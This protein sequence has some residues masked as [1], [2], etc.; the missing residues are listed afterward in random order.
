MLIG[1]PVLLHNWL[2]SF[3]VSMLPWIAAIVGFT[4]GLQANGIFH[5]WGHFIGAR[6]LGGNVPTNPWNKL[7]PM[8]HFDMAS[9]SHRQF[10]GM[11]I[12]GTVTEFLFPLGLLVVLGTGDLVT[13]G[14][15]AGAFA[16]AILGILTEGPVIKRAIIMGDGIAAWQEYLTYRND[17][18]RKIKLIAVP[19]MFSVLAAVFLL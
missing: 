19:V 6:I 5:E 18:L 17:H 12:G 8:F 15:V 13:K 9:N 7:F 14:L 16:A 11:S 4:A 10:M 2:I 1:L 3:E